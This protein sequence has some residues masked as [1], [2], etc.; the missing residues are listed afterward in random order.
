[1]RNDS[2]VGNFVEVKNAR[3][4]EGSKANHL[5]YLGDA[6]IGQRTN[7]GAGVITCNY[8]GANKFKTIIGN[9]VF[10]GSDSQLVAPVTIAD[11]ATIG[12]GT[13]L[14]KDVAE[15]ELVIT[16]AKERKITGWQRP[17]K[18]K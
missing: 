8:D 15:G 12:A 10:V 3:L 18:K 6:E 17:V 13:T 4:G 14:T 1:M 11:G 9:D 2:H 5:T 7:V 16:R